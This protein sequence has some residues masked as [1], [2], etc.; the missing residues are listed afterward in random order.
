V[1]LHVSI[2]RDVLVQAL[3]SLHENKLRTVLSILGITVG[4][5]AV[6]VVGT[7]SQGVKKYVYAELETYGLE[8]LW[9]YRKWEDDNPFRTARQ[10]SGIDNDDLKAMRS[11]CP[12]VRRVSPV[13]YSDADYITL[14]SKGNFSNTNLEGVGIHYLGINNDR[15]TVGR[16]LRSEDIQRRKPVAIIGTK[17]RDELF[18]EHA[19]PIK[20]VIR[21]GNVRLT[22]IGLLE[23]K[24][25]DLLTQLGADDYDINKRVLIPYTLYQQQL[26][27][28]DVHTLQAEATGVVVTTQAL[29]ELTEL[30]ERRHGNR[31]E[32]V[33]E[34]MDGWIDTA[35]GILRN[36]TLVGLVAASISLLVGGLG[37]MNIMSTSV[38]ERTREI[39]I[40]K[41]LGAYRRD[42]LAQFLMEATAVSIIG[43]V[44][45]MVLGIFTGHAISYFSG[46]DLGVSWSSAI[47]AIIVSVGVGMLSGYYPAHRAANM[48]PVDALRYE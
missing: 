45:G 30:L 15:L 7:V 34:S 19:N 13:V 12:S 9:V 47:L 10:G 2:F 8:T 44:L 27:S 4:I 14:R 5:A 21:W 28:K 23:E 39:G 11:C 22:V 43:G 35:E 26:G 18:G 31:Y 20:K 42:I 36:I 1:I 16:N 17:V 29:A 40:R 6:M 48:K 41:A 3:S 24:N 46:Y 37:I 25:R 32:Y 33:T 38:V